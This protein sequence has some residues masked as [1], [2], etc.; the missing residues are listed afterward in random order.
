MSETTFSK[1]VQPAVQHMTIEE[2]KNQLKSI[3]IQTQT[4]T[5]TTTPKSKLKNEIKTI[6]KYSTLAYLLTSIFT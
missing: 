1:K 4:I 5:T 3:S 6:L 2:T